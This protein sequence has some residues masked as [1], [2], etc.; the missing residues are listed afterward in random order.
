MTTLTAAL[1]RRPMHEERDACSGRYKTSHPCDGCNRPVGTD[2]CT[3]S[4]VCGGTDGPGFFLCDR[5]SCAKKL[6]GLGVEARRTV[7]TANRASRST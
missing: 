5:K 7:Y 3:D 2:H 6:D 1:D 4:E